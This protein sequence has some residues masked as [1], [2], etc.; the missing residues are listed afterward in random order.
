MIY[1]KNIRLRNLRLYDILLKNL[2]PVFIQEILCGLHK[3]HLSIKSKKLNT[4]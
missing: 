4:S 2:M 3:I 1:S